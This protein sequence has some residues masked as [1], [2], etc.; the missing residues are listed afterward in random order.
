[1]IARLA[2][3]WDRTF[4]FKDERR[5][6]IR[7]VSQYGTYESEADPSRCGNS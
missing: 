5:R 4:G 1:M 3:L 6:A 2:A 7:K